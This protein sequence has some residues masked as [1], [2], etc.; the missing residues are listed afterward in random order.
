MKIGEVDSG[1]K[2]QN[3]LTKLEMPPGEEWEKNFLST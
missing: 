1:V 2:A 3:F